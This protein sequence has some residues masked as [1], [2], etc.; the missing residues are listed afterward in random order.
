MWMEFTRALPA[1]ILFVIVFQELKALFIKQCS[2]HVDM[3]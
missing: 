3:I 2:F 1:Y